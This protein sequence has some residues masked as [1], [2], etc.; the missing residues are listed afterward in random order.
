M[1][2]SNKLILAGYGLS[3]AYRLHVWGVSA[4]PE[5]IGNLLFSY[6][7][8]L[9]LYSFQIIAAG[10]VK[11]FSVVGGFIHFQEILTCI[12]MSFLV[13]AVFSIVKLLYTRS[14]LVGMRN[15]LSFFYAKIKGEKRVYERDFI[16]KKN[17]MHF[18]FAILVGTM[19]ARHCA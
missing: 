10:D 12:G 14:F 15:G 5:W 7:V 18:S 17:L 6:A 1:K 11:L 9:V 4:V 19:I 2:I 3:L 8:L 13:A 16:K